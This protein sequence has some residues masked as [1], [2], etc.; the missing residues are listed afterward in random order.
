MAKTPSKRLVVCL[1]NEGYAAS[2]ERRKIYIALPDPD[3]DKNGLLRI[4]DE[5][6][7][8]YLY[9]KASFSPITLPP[10]LKKAVLAA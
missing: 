2:L 10:P 4:I 3:A 1:D 7:E 8:D 6:G 9:P 5:S